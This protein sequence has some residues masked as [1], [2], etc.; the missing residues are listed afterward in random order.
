MHGAGGLVSPY[1]P[2][3]VAKTLTKVLD[4]INPESILDRNIHRLDAMFNT[5]V[6]GVDSVVDHTAMGV[7][8]VVKTG[9]DALVG[10]E[11]GLG[12][13]FSSPAMVLGAGV[14]AY[15]AFKN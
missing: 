9:G 4:T 8:G 13:I 2:H 6:A 15:M 3:S 5:G 1:L 14:V 7:K 12:S 11:K 10:A